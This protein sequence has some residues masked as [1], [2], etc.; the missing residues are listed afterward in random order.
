[1]KVEI[2]VTRVSML[3][4]K[5]H[6]VKLKLDPNDYQKWQDG[7]LIQNAMPYLTADERE[8]LMTGITKEEWDTCFK[9]SDK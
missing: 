9:G 8:F 3:S 4:H 6:T 2:A 5:E 7:A 1:M